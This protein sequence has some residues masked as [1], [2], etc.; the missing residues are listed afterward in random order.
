VNAVPNTRLKTPV[1]STLKIKTTNTRQLD[2]ITST[3]LVKTGTS[4]KTKPLTKPS[5]AI[6]MIGKTSQQNTK[7]KISMSQSKSSTATIGQK[8]P[9]SNARKSV[10]ISRTTSQKS[11][12]VISTRENTKRIKRSHDNFD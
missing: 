3:R 9:L 6:T 12:P 5:G 11:K 1:S 4:R 10:S 2:P 7:P 8:L